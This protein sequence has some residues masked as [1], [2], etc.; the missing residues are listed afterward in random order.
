MTTNV[1]IIEEYTGNVLYTMPA[2]LFTRASGLK[3]R[4]ELSG[5]EFKLNKTTYKIIRKSAEISA[6]P[7]YELYVREV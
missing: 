6:F 7:T 4:D 1:T 3:I 2:N 5:L